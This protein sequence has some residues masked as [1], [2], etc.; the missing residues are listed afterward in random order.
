MTRRALLLLPVLLT[1]RVEAAGFHITGRLDCTE[2]E[3]QEGYF[4]IGHDCAIVARPSSPIH[5]DL[6][7]MRG[8]DVQCSVFN[9]GPVEREGEP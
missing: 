8:T 5:D 2:Q 9:P 7:A 4:A 1:T 6:L 3:A